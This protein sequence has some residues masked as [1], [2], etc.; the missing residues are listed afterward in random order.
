MAFLPE[1][2]FLP[3]LGREKNR[4]ALRQL[5]WVTNL[6]ESYPALIT[7]EVVPFC[8][9]SFQAGVRFDSTITSEVERRV[10][11]LFAPR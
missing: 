3:Y 4:E 9:L 11:A 2:T 6:G 1:V 7:V 8:H 5:A 10:R